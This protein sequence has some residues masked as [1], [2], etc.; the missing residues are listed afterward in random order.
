MRLTLAV[1]DLLALDRGALA[2]APALSTLA[3]YARKPDTR[4]GTLDAFLLADAPDAEPMAAAPFAAL[5]AGLDPGESY[6]LRADPVSLVAG[7]N[8]VALAARIGDL[9]AGETG[10]L[11][12]T[13]NAHFGR[14]GLSFHAPRPDCVVHPDRRDARHYD[15]AARRRARRD[16]SLASRRWRRG[17][18]A[19]LA[20]RN[21]D[22]AARTCGER[23]AR[24]AG[25]R[26]GDGHLDLG[27][28]S[29][30]A[31]TA[32][33]GRR[34]RSRRPARP[35]T[36]RAG[37]RA[38]TEALPAKRR[39]VSRHCRRGIAPS[40]LPNARIPRAPRRLQ[41]DWLGPAVAALERGDLE[42][43]SLLADGHGIAAAWH[44]S[45]P[46]WR[47]RAS[48][49]YAARSFMPPQREEDDA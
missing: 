1:P 42:S 18:L 21:A 40:S 43:L 8:D 26:A 30:R 17:A 15:D 24:G 44:A 3:H 47:M 2:G 31:D 29:P 23:R 35:A 33:A 32:G 45:R 25:T 41:S 27:R 11:I 16:L 37:W 4:R 34:R 12:A 49:K 10:M 22:V 20:E 19:A 9:D 28:R 13:L 7:R 5:G 38:R 36:S 48:A 39:R 46:G 14:D 6:V